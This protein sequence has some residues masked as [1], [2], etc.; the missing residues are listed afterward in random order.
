MAFLSLTMLTIRMA[1]WFDRM[2]GRLW[3]LILKPVLE[4]PYYSYKSFAC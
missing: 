2:I 3:V 4:H 1:Y